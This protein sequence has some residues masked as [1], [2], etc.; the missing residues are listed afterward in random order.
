MTFFCQWGEVKDMGLFRIQI[1]FNPSFIQ[2]TQRETN[3][4]D[5]KYHRIFR[6]KSAT[7]SCLLCYLIG[8]LITILSMDC[9]HHDFKHGLKPINSFNDGSRKALTNSNLLQQISQVFLWTLIPDPNLKYLKAVISRG[10]LYR[11]LRKKRADTGT[12]YCL[13]LL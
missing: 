7:A 2:Q 1:Q 12:S 13:L 6:S 10:T 5:Q 8:M 11:L 3:T 9:A 4:D